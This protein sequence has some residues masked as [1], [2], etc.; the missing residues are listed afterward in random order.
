MFGLIYRVLLQARTRQAFAM[1]RVFQALMD[2]MARSEECWETLCD[3]DEANVDSVVEDIGVHCLVNGE[4]VGC[5]DQCTVNSSGIGNGSGA[6]EEAGGKHR[7]LKQGRQLY[8]Q[9]LQN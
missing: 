1:A 6:T 9:A 4:T 7:R 2:A 8:K 5:T 3:L